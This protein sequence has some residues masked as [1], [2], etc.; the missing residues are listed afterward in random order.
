MTKVLDKSALVLS[1]AALLLLTLALVIAYYNWDFDD[2][3]IVYRYARNIISGDGWRYNVSENYNASTS[4]LNTLLISLLSLFNHDPRAAGHLVGGLG[5]FSSGVSVLFLMLKR[6]GVFIATMSAAAIV[7][8]LG[9]NQTWGIETN[10][11]IA[12]TLLF[13]L[14]ETYG[15]NT[16][17]LAG[18]IMLARPDGAL[19]FIAKLAVV[20]VKERRIPWKGVFQFSAVVLPWFIYSFYTFHNIFPATLKQKVWQGSSGFWGEGLVYLQF[21]KDTAIQQQMWLEILGIPFLAG[22]VFLVYERSPLLH[23][24]VFTII[25]QTVYVLLNVPGYHW[26]LAPTKAAF[27]LVAAFGIAAAARL[28]WS[29]LPVSALTMFDNNN[30]KALISCAVST[31]LLTGSV[32]LYYKITSN[33]HANV[34]NVESYKELSWAINQYEPAGTVAALEVGVVGY[35]TN[36]RILDILGLTSSQGEFSSGMNNDKFYGILPAVIVVH[37][38]VSFKEKAIV[39]DPR[40]KKFY[41]LK[42]TVRSTDYQD[43]LFFELARQ[44][45]GVL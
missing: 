38:N 33:T 23:L 17:Y 13:V 29:R 15:Y 35:Y 32:I 28:A 7:L 21:L 34:P 8:L 37:S 39:S 30:Y 22:L 45:K 26:Y 11:F 18:F 40:F 12:L 3:F 20:A 9:Y 5:I 31:A 2:S 42:G 19:F 1:L 16:W 6:Y 41:T 25:Q 27:V 44:P 14:L 10:L 43:V 24:S 36:R 4:T